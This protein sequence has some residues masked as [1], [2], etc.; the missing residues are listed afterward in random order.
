[1]PMLP[2]LL[3]LVAA[4]GF[5]AGRDEL[6]IPAVL[7]I[8]FVVQTHGSY[9]LLGPAVLTGAV[10][11]RFALRAETPVARRPLVVA[12]VAGFVVWL[13][14]IIDQLFRSHNM[15]ALLTHATSGDEGRALGF[16][17]A[18]R[19]AATV[20]VK[21]PL[22]TR[23]GMAPSLANSGGMVGTARFSSQAA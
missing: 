17:D 20:L 4:W 16:S 9:L 12:G 7:A 10:A 11:C 21:P 19:A 15:S 23:P 6:A 14:P 1:M 13:Q 22:W 3:A 18:V 2:F 5:A 8:S